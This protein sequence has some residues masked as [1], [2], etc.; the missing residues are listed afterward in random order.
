MAV[1]VKIVSLA[2]MAAQTN[3]PPAEDVACGIRAMTAI[4]LQQ[5]DVTL[6]PKEFKAMAICISAV[7]LSVGRIKARQ[8]INGILEHRN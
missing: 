4:A 7:G 8:E 3:W 2:D 6:T 5:S 1:Q